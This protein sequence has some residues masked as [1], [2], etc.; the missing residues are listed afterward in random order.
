M[1]KNSVYQKGKFI[2]LD[3][4]LSSIEE[5]VNLDFSEFICV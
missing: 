2:D 3:Q 1:G 4:D 5:F